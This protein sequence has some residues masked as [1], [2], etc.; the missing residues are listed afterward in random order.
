MIVPQKARDLKSNSD[1]IWNTFT[2]GEVDDRLLLKQACQAVLALYFVTALKLKASIL[3]WIQI[4][5]RTNPRMGISS[6]LNP[7]RKADT[8][9]ST[10]A[11][12]LDRWS[13]LS[14]FISLRTLSVCNLFSVNRTVFNFFCCWMGHWSSNGHDAQFSFENLA[15]YTFFSS[16]Y[17]DR[18]G[19]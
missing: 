19:L 13:C 14:L 17:F 10:P 12:K 11:L 9:P 5:V 3:E 18:T 1:F 4:F 2:N 16:S 8:I 6:I 15:V 7:L